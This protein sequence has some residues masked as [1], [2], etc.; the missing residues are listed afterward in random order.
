MDMSWKAE[1][2]CRPLDPDLFFPVGNTGPA[3]AQANEA[4]AVCLGCPVRIRCRNYA[5][6]RPEVHG[7]WGGMTEEERAALQRRARRQGLAV[8]DVLHEGAA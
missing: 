3:M 2:A 8:L 6:K 5:L 1:G 4:K 7:V